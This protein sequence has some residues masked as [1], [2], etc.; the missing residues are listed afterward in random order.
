MPLWMKSEEI[1]EFA[2]TSMAPVAVKSI[3]MTDPMVILRAKGRSS[4]NHLIRAAD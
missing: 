4:R 2:R 1:E 3:R